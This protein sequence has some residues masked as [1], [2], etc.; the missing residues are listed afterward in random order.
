MLWF[1]FTSGSIFFQTSLFFSNW[2]LF[3]QPVYFFKTVIL[4]EDLEQDHYL[5]LRTDITFKTLNTD[6]K[7]L[8]FILGKGTCLVQCYK[9]CSLDFNPRAL[10][11]SL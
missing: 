4:I 7:W 6:F 8:A 9:V 5:G 2:F 10:K 1:N 11:G 3:F